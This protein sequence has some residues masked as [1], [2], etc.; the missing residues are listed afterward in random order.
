MP[1]AGRKGISM[2]DPRVKYVPVEAVKEYIKR[3]VWLTPEFDEMVEKYGIDVVHYKNTVTVDDL[4]MRAVKNS[5][6][7]MDVTD[8]V[9]EVVASNLEDAIAKHVKC[10]SI[11]YYPSRL[12]PGYHNTEYRYDIM[13]GEIPKGQQKEAE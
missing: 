2:D 9:K 8:Y 3:Y 1:T 10:T 4:E 13:I 5:T 6:D 11:Q 7:W 12:Y